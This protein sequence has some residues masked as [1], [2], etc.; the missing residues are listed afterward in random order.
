MT[1]KSNAVFSPLKPEH[2]DRMEQLEHICFSVPWS[3]EALEC[4]LCNP[5]ARYVVCELDGTVVGYIG[6]LTAADVCDITNV[7]VDP[8]YRRRHLAT[9]MLNELLRQVPQWGV[10]SLTLEVRESNAS[11][12]A[13]YEKNGFTPVGR[14]KNY[15]EK[16][17]EDAILMSRPLEDKA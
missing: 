16:P 4:E 15:Y 3:R 14:R 1:L 9:A 11:A 2:I 8:Q 17:E 7:A 12:R 5:C 6:T 10:S 13:F